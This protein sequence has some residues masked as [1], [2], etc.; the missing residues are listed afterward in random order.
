VLLQAEQSGRIVPLVYDPALPVHT[1]WDLGTSV[2]HD[3]NS[4][5]FVQLQGNRVLVIDYLQA[6]NQGIPFYVQA[7]KDKQY[8]YGHHWALEAD[9][10]EADW[11]NG[12]TRGTQLQAFGLHFTLL[13]KL[14]VID[15]IHQVRSLIA[16]CL[17]DPETTRQGLNGLRSYKRQ[18]NDT[19]KRFEDHPVH[20]WASLPAS[21]FR[22]LALGISQLDRTGLPRQKPVPRSRGQGGAG[23]WMG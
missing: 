21:A 14:A 10:A 11:G 16:R 13:P 20:D 12:Q 3:T 8:L 19:H 5:W 2:A 4:I 17:F 23:G 7:L 1:A 9:L 15:G 6:S 18:W 22:Y